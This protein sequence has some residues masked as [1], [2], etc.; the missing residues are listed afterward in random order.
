MSNLSTATTYPMRQKRVRVADV[1]RCLPAARK[2]LTHER[3]DFEVGDTFLGWLHL[4]TEVLKL[5]C[6]FSLLVLFFLPH[7]K[8][9][10]SLG[11][12]LAVL[13]P[14]Y[15]FSF[16]SFPDYLWEQCGKITSITSSVTKH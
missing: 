13:F 15:P 8:W 12:R 7:K 10:N 14:M 5:S 4:E 2:D 11:F 6:S 16:F 1:V 9:E 3:P